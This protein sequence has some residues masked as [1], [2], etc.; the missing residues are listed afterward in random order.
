MKSKTV[1]L[2]M[3]FAV[4][5]FSIILAWLGYKYIL[6]GLNKP[7]ARGNFSL[8]DVDP[9]IESMFIIFNLR[10]EFNSSGSLLIKASPEGDYEKSIYKYNINDHSFSKSS[11][12]SWNSA[13]SKIANCHEPEV[14]RTVKQ[15][16]HTVILQDKELTTIGKYPFTS[17]SSANGK[18]YAVISVEGPIKYYRTPIPIVPGS[19]SGVKG[20]R[21]SEIFS[22]PQGKSIIPPIEIDLPEKN[23]NASMC[24][25][26]D[27]KFLVIAK[28]DLTVQIV[29]IDQMINTNSDITTMNN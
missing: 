27:D 7:L 21:Y 3:S 13:Q 10:R 8:K 15:Q 11:L 2:L 4:V 23:P 24:W 5:V 1:I 19:Y 26:A 17:K 16:E 14:N 20:K 29:E 28:N 22:M 12:E 25:S 9:K 6:D 18:Y